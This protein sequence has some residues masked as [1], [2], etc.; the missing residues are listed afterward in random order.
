MANRRNVHVVPRDTGWAVVRE[1][2]KR[3]SE[4]TGT[5]ADAVAAARS[6][7]QA[8]KGEL[9]IHGENGRIRARD[10]FGNDPCPPRDAR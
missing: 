1:G 10:S 7:A 6:L 3:A 4:V 9:L 8:G 5:Q 2:A